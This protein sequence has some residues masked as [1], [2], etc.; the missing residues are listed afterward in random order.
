MGANAEK[1]YSR[2]GLDKELRGKGAIGLLFATF[3]LPILTTRSEDVPDLEILSE[4]VAAGQTIDIKDSG[5]HGENATLY[6]KRMHDVVT[7]TI[8]YGWI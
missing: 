2:I 7:D 6:N 1:L 8:D 3:V 5:I 4:K